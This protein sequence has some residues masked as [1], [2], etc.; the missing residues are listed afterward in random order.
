MDVKEIAEYLGFSPTKIYRMLTSGE[1]P[2]VKVGGQYRF[3]K[4][5]I[6]DWLA[7]KLEVPG[8]GK[9]AM[10][11]KTRVARTAKAKKTRV[12]DE[13]VERLIAFDKTGTAE[14][15]AK[16]RQITAKN[17]DNIDWQYLA[18]KAESAGV[19]SAAIEMLEKEKTKGG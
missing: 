19:L 7:G 15:Q 9:T 17:I 8:V 2:N 10:A 3:P 1:I 14:A 18:K 4:D 16:A 13:I 6:D 12:E 11:T 5:V